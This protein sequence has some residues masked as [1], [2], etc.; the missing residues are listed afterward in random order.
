MP[1]TFSSFLT[2]ENFNINNRRDLKAL[3][4]RVKAN[5]AAGELNLEGH[6]LPTTLNAWIERVE[7]DDKRLSRDVDVVDFSLADD[8]KLVAWKKSYF[9]ELN[10]ALAAK[11]TVYASQEVRDLLE[12]V[13]ELEKANANSLNL[14]N[15]NKDDLVS[16][17]S[18]LQGAVYL[19]LGAYDGARDKLKLPARDTPLES[20]KVRQPKKV[21][22]ENEAAETKAVKPKKARAARTKEKQASEQE[23]AVN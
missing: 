15:G 17:L 11:K 23:A 16:G 5:V 2:D 12:G 20:V 3:Y 9:G 7:G 22:V 1:V 21:P 14:M 19:L 6:T 4:D 13:Q 10:R 8:K 18:D